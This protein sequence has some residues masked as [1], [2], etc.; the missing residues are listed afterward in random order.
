M[1]RLLLSDFR[2]P[3]SIIVVL[4][5]FAL[6][7]CNKPNNN[8]PFAS[9][10]YVV[11]ASN[12]LGM[13]CLNPTYDQAVILPPYNTV[14]AQVVKRG[15]PPVIT[16]SGITVEYKIIENTSS[17]GKRQ[18]GGFWDHITA[19]FGMASLQHDIGLTGNGLSG[20]MTAASGRF[21][22]TGIPVVPV[23]DQGVWDPLQV[24][25]IT[26]KDG[27]GNTVAT[28]RATVPT[29]DEINCAKC[30]GTDAFNDV[31]AKHDDKVGTSLMQSKP[32]LCAKC[33]GSEAL[34]MT[35]RGSSGK[36]LSE[37]IHGYHADK[38]ASC[39]D[40][41]PGQ[42]TK[43]NRS[44]KHTAADGNCVTCHG[45]MA[46]V[47]SSTSTRVP[48]ANEPSCST[49]HNEATD[50]G[51]TSALYRESKGH[52]NM[53]CTSCHGS[54]HA[55]VPSSK[56]VDNYQAMQYQPYST[57]PK[58]LGSC[59]TCHD[60]SRGVSDMGEYA[61]QHGGSNPETMNGCFICHTSVSTST[62]DWPHA[63]TWKN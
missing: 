21:E 27:S 16:T 7:G 29:S 28:T 45:T 25:E 14:L 13:H 48:W 15:N 17:Y 6:A 62:G 41:H 43:C 5:I 63:Y 20:T 52:G 44:I 23:N 58:T 55:M 33:H 42:T 35:G 8:P 1:K 57:S 56:D 31:L 2:L 4:S 49:C 37:A 46:Q 54:P 40:C 10:D 50:V 18:Y 12:S 34:G 11:F 39:Y 47:A 51:S 22:A 60:S 9:S 61:G 32:V 53:A 59:G 36:Y 38:G 26:V 30:H 3:T 24:A 19:L